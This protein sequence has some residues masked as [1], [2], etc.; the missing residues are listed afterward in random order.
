MVDAKVYGSKCLSLFTRWRVFESL[1]P[2]KRQYSHLRPRFQR[3]PEGS[4]NRTATLRREIR[5]FLGS[6]FFFLRVIIIDGARRIKKLK[7]TIGRN[8][9]TSNRFLLRKTS[10]SRLP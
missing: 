6:I 1:F 10:P 4:R 5:T 7:K 9:K 3:S 2:C 8:L